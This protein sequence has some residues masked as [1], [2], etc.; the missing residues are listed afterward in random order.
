MKQ[1]FLLLWMFLW[2]VRIGECA[3]P[4]HSY[5][6]ADCLQK[7]RERAARTAN[8][9]RMEVSAGASV[10]EARAEAL[11]HLDLNGSYTRID[12]VSTFDIG[13][14]PIQIGSEDNY[15]VSAG[16]SQVLYKGGQ[17]RAALRAAKV[18]QDYARQG[19][20]A[21]EAA[22]ERD[23]CLAFHGLQLAEAETAVENE[24]VLQL[25]RMVASAES[26]LAQQTIPE[27]ELLSARVRLANA[28]PRQIAASNRLEICRENLRT[29]AYLDDGDYAL[30]GRLVM[31]QEAR[32]LQQYLEA[33]LQSRPELAQLESQVRL[34]REGC[35]VAEAAYKPAIRAFGNYQGGNSS[36]Y[37][38]M[39][40]EWDWHWTAG[41]T[42]EWAFS[43]GGRRSAVW[44]QKKLALESTQADLEEMRRMV[45][46]EVRQAF[47]GLKYAEEAILVARE[48]EALAERGLAI[49]AV[50]HAQGIATY[51]E[52]TET[53]LAL[54]TARL[55]MLQAL[56]SHSAARVKVRFAA[57]LPV[58][59]EREDE[60]PVAQ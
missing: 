8:A 49:A 24:S 22:L 5:T 18:Y 11:P 42:V 29:L 54:S 32:G 53:N 4:A 56:Y 7:G 20:R 38:P 48:T 58:E 36:A 9:R 47:L 25:R 27:F 2:L 45:A 43:D 15:V 17:V 35:N 44:L 51:L 23:I 1:A 59:E 14:G 10:R 26:Q 19:R 50:R 39:Q 37:A 12:E 55:Q 13:E 60:K 6:L 3:P 57:G 34:R 40:T 28:L 31:R 41:M 52:F 30:E 21:A 16:L 46:L 33:A